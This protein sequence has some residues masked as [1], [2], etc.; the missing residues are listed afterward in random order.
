M[1]ADAVQRIVEAEA[2]EAVS[3]VLIVDDQESIVDIIGRAIQNDNLRISTAT[4]GGKA[5]EMIDACD[6]DLVVVDIVMPGA[7]GISVLKHAK[8]RNPETEVIM[9]TG[10]ASVG[11]AA[12]AVRDG[13]ADYLLK[14][15]DNLQ[16]VVL[17]VRR[18]LTRRRLVR[19]IRKYSVL[20]TESNRKLEIQKEKYENL[21]HVAHVCVARTIESIQKIEA[22][23]GGQIS[24]ASRVE[25][26]GMVGDNEELKELVDKFLDEEGK[27]VVMPA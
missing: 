15:F 16:V 14:P 22:Q 1:A 24:E 7:S 9:M 10:Y 17:A 2:E 26:D 8:E 5:I 11:S 3:N 13:A 27:Q 6:F 21:A 23:L 20:L 18:A 4:D 25:I 12:E 19:L